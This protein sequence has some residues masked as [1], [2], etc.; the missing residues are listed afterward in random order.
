MNESELFNRPKTKKL[1]KVCSWCKKE[2]GEVDSVEEGI[3]HG[4]CPECAAKVRKEEFPKI[5]ENNKNH[6]I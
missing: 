1:K 2:M 5:L 4:I 6:A 3:S